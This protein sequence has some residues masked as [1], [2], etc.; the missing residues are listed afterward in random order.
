MHVHS[1][2][3]SSCKIKQSF[4][5]MIRSSFSAVFFSFS[6]IIPILSPGLG[7]KFSMAHAGDLNQHNL[8]YIK[9]R[10]RGIDKKVE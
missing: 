7:T 1:L 2:S 10:G 3:A 6:F 4:S 8:S 9:N 5:C